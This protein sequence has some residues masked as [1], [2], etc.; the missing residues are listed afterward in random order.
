[1][2]TPKGQKPLRRKEDSRIQIR[3]TST[4]HTRN[5]KPRLAVVSPFL[6]KSHGTERMVIEWLTRLVDRFEIHV[7]SQEIHDL[8]LSQITWHPILKLKGPHLFNFI[9]WFAANRWLRLWQRRF[10]G[11]RYD[12]VFSPGP[13]CFDADVIS[14]H[15]VF[16]A[17]VEFVG[18]EL[19]FAKNPVWS[20][21]RLLHRKMYYRLAT[22]LEKRAYTNPKIQ[23]ILTSP[24]SGQDLRRFYG[25]G[26]LS[27]VVSTGLDHETFSPERRG[28]LRPAARRELGMTDESFVILLIGNDLRKKGIRTLLSAL[29]RSHDLAIDL[30]VVGREDPGPFRAMVSNRDVWKR[31]HFLQP[32]PDVEYYYAAADAY[33][34]PSLED[35]FALPAAEAMACGLPVVI[36][37]KAGAA[38]WVTDGVDG[39]ILKDPND[40]SSLARIMRRLYGDR[41]FQAL[42]GARAAQKVREYTWERSAGEL[43]AI[44][45]DVLGRKKQM[46]RETPN[47]DEHGPLIR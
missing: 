9:W 33:M 2:Q 41:D 13:N 17:F 1:L 34:G 37:A 46:V 29:E 24:Q 8:D 36:S 4:M 32:R 20:W 23:L 12:L 42:L 21:P 26:T 14:V 30:I 3:R 25:P 19:R 6:D 31:V 44:F 27:R 28:L 38:Q 18:S 22:F 15:I 10:R 35:T 11:L 7:Y 45:E 16:A 5:H 40:A 47:L 39:V 43:A